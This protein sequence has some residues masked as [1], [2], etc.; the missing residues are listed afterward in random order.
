MWCVPPVTKITFPVRLG[1]SLSGV[2]RT[3]LVLLK[4]APMLVWAKLLVELWFCHI[5]YSM[6]NWRRFRCVTAAN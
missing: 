6:D 5:E 2:K 1:M 3:L 4:K